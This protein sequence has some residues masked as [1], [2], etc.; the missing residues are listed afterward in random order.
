[1]TTQKI[2]DNDNNEH[3]PVGRFMVAT[4]AIIT[5]NEGKILLIRRSTKLDWHPGEWEIMYG[6]IAQHEDPQDGL[7]REVKEELGIAVTVGKPLTAWH[8]Y[9]GHEKTAY[10][11]LIGITFLAKTSTTEIRLSDEHEEYRWVTP[12]EALSLV[13]VDGIKRDIN[14]YVNLLIDRSIGN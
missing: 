12:V 7:I 1:M 3:N 2:V 6:R 11:D 4:G 8:I 13:K 14:A 5:N 10:N 9:R